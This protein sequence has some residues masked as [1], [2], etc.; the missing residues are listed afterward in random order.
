MARVQYTVKGTGNNMKKALYIVIGVVVLLLVLPIA[1]NRLRSVN[2]LTFDD[3]VDAVKA[4]GFNP[5]SHYSDPAPG[6]IDGGIVMYGSS[7]RDGEIWMTPIIKSERAE[8]SQME[9]T[10]KDNAEIFYHNGWIFR[11]TDSDAKR[12]NEMV[13]MIRSM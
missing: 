6:R 8:A 7:Y 5:I 4:K 2:P 10:T 3:M 12:R 9:T 11:V 1:T 13:A